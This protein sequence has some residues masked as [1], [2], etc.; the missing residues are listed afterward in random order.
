MPLRLLLPNIRIHHARYMYIYI[1]P[2]CQFTPPLFDHRRDHRRKRAPVYSFHSVFHPVFHDGDPFS[3][4]LFLDFFFFFLSLKEIFS[5]V[6]TFGK[7]EKEN[8]LRTFLYTHRQI[9]C[10]RYEK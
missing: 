3:L 2:C 1:P 6:H 7:E 5:F 8:F 10:N 9:S 4:G